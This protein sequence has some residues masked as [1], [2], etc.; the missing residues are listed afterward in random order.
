M[1]D[2]YVSGA[3]VVTRRFDALPGKLRAELKLAITRLTT[4]L[5]RHVMANK[6]SGQ[7]LNVRTGTLR[8]SI[9]QLVVDGGNTIVGKVSTNVSY[10]KKH[11][12]GFNGSETIESHLREI[13]KAW[14]RSIT[15]KQ[16]VVREHTRRVALPER[17]FL[18]SALRD[19]AETGQ[20]NN[21]LEAAV[22]RAAQ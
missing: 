8:R 13:K 20:I 19:F 3:E 4:K 18:R 9:D 2:A 17:S 14:G 11:E 6:L 22:K 5:Q 12:Y 1:I 16:V 21:E 7:V 15:P 10:G